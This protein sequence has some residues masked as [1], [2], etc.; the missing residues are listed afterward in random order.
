M[1]MNSSPQ[2][3]KN[4]LIVTPEAVRT[5]ETESGLAGICS[6]MEQR[7]LIK[8]VETAGDAR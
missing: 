5:F 3:N 2:G 8:I 6:L 7:G 4:P 1:T